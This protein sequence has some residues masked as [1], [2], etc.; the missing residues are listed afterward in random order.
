MANPSQRGQA[1]VPQGAKG[2]DSAKDAAIAA[3]NALPHI[4]AG[5]HAGVILKGPDGK[6]YATAPIMT[7][8]DDFQLHVP[9]QKG[10]SMAGIYHNHPGSD[11]LA[12]YFSPGDIQ[13][14][15]K[16]KVPSYIRFSADNVIRGYMPGQTK[17]DVR[18]PNED[19]DPMDAA[20][21]TRGEQVYPI[22]QPTAPVVAAPRVGT[23]T[24]PTNDINAAVASYYH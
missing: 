23:L 17:L 12:Q 15:D 24:V 10:W 1:L 7:A 22:V 6:Y 13:M 8:Q 18:L 14:A 5:E 16:L 2:L 4:K 19:G 3:L 9:I 21:V 11:G 20:R